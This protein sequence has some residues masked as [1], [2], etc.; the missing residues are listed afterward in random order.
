MLGQVKIGGQ[1]APLCQLTANMPLICLP[2][3]TDSRSQPFA[4]VF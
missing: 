3:A 1:V 2:I 4:G